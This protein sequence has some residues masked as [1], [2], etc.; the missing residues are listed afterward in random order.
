MNNIETIPPHASTD[1]FEDTMQIAMYAAFFVDGLRDENFAHACA[2]SES[3]CIEL[4]SNVV[5]YAPHLL[6]LVRAVEAVRDNSAGYPGVFEY[7]VANAF[8]RMITNYVITHKNLPIED[9]CKAWLASEVIAFF[10][11]GEK[12]TVNSDIQQAVATVH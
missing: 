9:T 2:V 7:E 3:G 11:N 6:K 8:G 5:G 10:S 4:V 12:M 1:A